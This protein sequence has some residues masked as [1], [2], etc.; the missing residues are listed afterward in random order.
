MSHEQEIRDRLEFHSLDLAERLGQHFLIDERVIDGLAATVIEGS[1]VIEVGS[2][3]GH[4]TEAIAQRAS[5]VFGI[6]VDRRFQPILE[7]IQERNSRIRFIFGDAL[8]VR[9]G[10]LIGRDNEVQVIA[11]LPFHIT[12]PFM[13]KLIDLPISNAI[14]MLGDNVAREFQEPESSMGFGKLSLLGQTF[15]DSRILTQVPRESFYPQPRTDAVMMEFDPKDRREIEAN[16]AN[17]VF[18]YL[19][20]RAGKFGLVVNEMKQAL[21]DASQRSGG[22]YLSKRESH[23]RDR[24]NVKRE[25]RQMLGEYNS[26]GDVSVFSSHDRGRNG[27]IV[28]QAQALDVIR[29]MGIPESVLGKPF[30]RLDNQD[31]RV[32]AASVREF[33]SR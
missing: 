5:S 31:V 17:Y 12:E 1:K 27:A 23:R 22:S 29:K 28:S 24:S 9:F 10:D 8:R 3:I 15:F 21:V 19:F 18:A 2:G 25:L 4:V 30:F 7:G 26:S 13:Y 6:E 32:L 14:L 33:Y 16:P 11:N 20:R